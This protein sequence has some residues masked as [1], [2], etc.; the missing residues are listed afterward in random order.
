MRCFATGTTTRYAA[1]K[2][3]LVLTNGLRPEKLA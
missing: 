2:L 3:L 1:V